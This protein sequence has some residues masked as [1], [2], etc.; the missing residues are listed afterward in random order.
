M[1][2]SKPYAGISGTAPNM[3]YARPNNGQDGC[4]LSQMYMHAVWQA[5]EHGTQC[6]VCWPA[7]R[8]VPWHALA[9]RH[10]RIH[11]RAREPP[12]FAHNLLMGAQW[13]DTWE[14]SGPTLAFLPFKWGSTTPLGA[15]LPQKSGAPAS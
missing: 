4:N 10:L 11:Q 8:N 6:A 12:K 15:A 2:L 9:F 1:L 5:E 13:S 3:L 7:E 14:H